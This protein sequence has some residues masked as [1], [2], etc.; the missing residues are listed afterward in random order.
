MNRQRPIILI[1]LIAYIFLPTVFEWVT[2]ADRAWY[3]PFVIWLVVVIVAF[4]LQ[5]RRVDHDI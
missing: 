2:N 5:N 4:F 3:K 1:A